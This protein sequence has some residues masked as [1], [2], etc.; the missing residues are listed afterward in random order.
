M[1]TDSLR[2][3]G[4]ILQRVIARENLSREESCTCF[5]QLMRNQ[6][7][8]LHQ[9]ALLGALACKGETSEEISG[10]WQAIQE[11][12]T[13]QVQL[14]AHLDLVEN[15]GTGMDK[16]KTFNVSSAAAI[17]AAACG[18]TLARHGAR[19]LTSFCGTVD[20]LEAIGLDVDCPAELVAASIASTGLGLF[21][22][23]STQIH[24][25]GLGRILSQIRFGSVLN[26]AASLAN[27]VRPRLAVRGVYDPL[28]IPLVASVMHEIGFRK[29]WIVCGQDEASGHWMDELSVCGKTAITEIQE[30]QPNRQWELS[31]EDVGLPRYPFAAIA[32]T[33]EL[34]QE[35][36]RFLQTLDGTGPQACIDFTCLNAAAILCVSGIC[37]SPQEGFET[38]KQAIRQGLARAKLEQWITAQNRE[39][40]NGMKRLREALSN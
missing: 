17:V 29:A 21:N 7:P 32:A 40:S 20:I 23:M 2:T 15:C 30:G 4:T 28:L 38:S 37:A 22:G 33:G 14:P 24:P 11:A 25:A 35:K 12:D 39:P 13:C 3:F 1:H 10:A 18:A 34:Q 5:L 16:L 6:Q 27:P 9:G 19:A 8:D 31:P 36:S 26:I